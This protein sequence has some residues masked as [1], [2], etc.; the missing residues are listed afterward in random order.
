M[1]IRRRIKSNIRKQDDVDDNNDTDEAYIFMTM[2]TLMMSMMMLAVLLMLMIMKKKMMLMVLLLL[3]RMMMMMKR[4]S[5]SLF[6]F[7]NTATFRRHMSALQ[8]KYKLN[9]SRPSTI[10]A[11]LRNSNKNSAKYL[12]ALKN[13]L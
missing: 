3:L 13:K 5:L 6:V 10:D 4:K 2:T 8:V 12:K 1:K 7:S 9:K 11:G